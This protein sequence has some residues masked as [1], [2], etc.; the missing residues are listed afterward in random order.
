MSIKVLLLNPP[1]KQVYIR[2]YYCSKV[3]KSNYLFHPVD[4]LMLSG[5]LAERFELSIVDAM[6]DRLTEHACLALVEA[7]MPNVIIAMIGAVSLDEDSAF[8]AKLVKAGR[9]IVVSG[10][11]VLDNTAEWLKQHP[12]VDAALLDFTSGDI[13]HYVEGT[14]TPLPNLVTRAEQGS[15]GLERVFNEEFS[16]P[17]PRHDLFPSRHYRF[18][19][20]KQKAFAT[21][22]TDYGCPYKCS[23]CIMNT[24]GYKYRSAG[25]VIEELRFLKKIGKKDLFFIDQTFGCNAQRT[26]E[27]LAAMREEDLR[28]GWAC[29]SRADLLTDARLDAMQASGCHTIIIGVETG[30]DEVLRKYGKGCSLTQIKEAFLKCRSRGIRTVATFILGLP[31]ETEETALA[32]IAFAKELDPDFSSFNIA[33]PRMSTALRQE[34]I[35]DRLI[36]PDLVTMDQTGSHI[37]MPTRHLTKEQLKRLSARAIREFYLRPGYLLRRLAGIT[38]F[39]EFKEH[40]SEG[41]SVLSKIMGVKGF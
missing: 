23:F 31:D 28:F 15:V 19:F 30:S 20:V 40:L 4:L 41:W 32:T 11:V 10:D 7:H 8:L 1:G 38:T 14:T 21:V 16:L 26:T 22:L 17:I 39:Y 3:S 34:A 2:D 25:N 36:A 33:V 29:F 9:R 18:P 6:A 24:I 13:V 12:F 27:L 5:R 37:A 35:Q